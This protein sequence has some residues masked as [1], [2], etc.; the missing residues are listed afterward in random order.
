MSGLDWK[1]LLNLRFSDG[2][3]MS[4]PAATAYALM[5]TGDRKCLEFLSTIVN[6]FNGGGKCVPN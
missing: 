5:E 2:S 1:R 4:S 6:K 3:F